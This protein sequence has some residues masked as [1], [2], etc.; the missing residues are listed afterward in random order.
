MSVKSSDFFNAVGRVNGATGALFNGRGAGTTRT[1]IGTYNIILDQAQGE[2]DGIVLITIYGE[3]GIG[4]QYT[5]KHL[6]DA[7]KEI[8]TFNSAGG[9][10]DKDFAFAVFRFSP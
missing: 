1:G 5:Y 10:E 2:N 3:P 7:I 6:S 4:A 8:H 9:P